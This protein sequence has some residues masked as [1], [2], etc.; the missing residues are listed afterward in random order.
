[1]EIRFVEL[2]DASCIAKIYKHYVENTIITFETIAPTTK[3]IEQRIQATSNKYPYIVAV[4]EGEL[5]GYAYAS[6]YRTRAAYDSS[7]ELSIYVDH[8]KRHTGVGK[9]LFETLLDLLV[10]QGFTMAYG[11]LACPNEPSEKLQ[12][13][14][15][16]ESIGIFKK[17]GY[18][19]DQ[20]I[21]TKWYQKELN[22]TQCVRK[23]VKDVE[24]YFKSKSN[25]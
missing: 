22:K 18:K 9:Q 8:T 6:A 15:G 12:K 13:Y 16:F 7:V 2:K 10:Y 4:V 25:G 20:Q 17:S 5:I 21:D 19:F 23:E 11:C 14:F 1:M 3:D 24:S